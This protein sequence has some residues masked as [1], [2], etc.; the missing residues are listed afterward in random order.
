V[1]RRLSRT[2]VELSGDLV[3]PVLGVNSR[4]GALREGLPATQKN[5][6]RRRSRPESAELPGRGS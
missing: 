1:D 5:F 4:V 2:L 3:R 6:E